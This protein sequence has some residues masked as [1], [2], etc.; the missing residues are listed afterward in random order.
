MAKV[1]VTGINR[2]QVQEQLDKVLAKLSQTPELRFQ[3]EAFSGAS[4]TVK[5][6]AELADEMNDFGTTVLAT[7]TAIRDPRS[8]TEDTTQAAALQFL[9][10]VVQNKSRQWGQY[11]RVQ[12]AGHHAL[13]RLAKT[14]TL[15]ER[16]QAQVRAL[17]EQLPP[18]L[19]QANT[20]HEI[21]HY[22]VPV[23]DP[24]WQQVGTQLLQRA[25]GDDRLLTQSQSAMLQSSKAPLA[26]LGLEKDILALEAH[27]AKE[28]EEVDEVKDALAM[29]VAPQGKLTIDAS[30]HFDLE[31]K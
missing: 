2:I 17:L 27:Y 9:G 4:E 14:Q 16:M 23:W 30:E 7:G 25:R 6:L 29:Y 8:Q 10:D 28:L 18:M 1:S 19:E 5:R 20:A 3:A 11:D 22:V 24:A 31:R 15:S 12:Q 21:D 26:F 13:G